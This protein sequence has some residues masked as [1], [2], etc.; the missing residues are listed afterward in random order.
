LFNFSINVKY[1]FQATFTIRG[2]DNDSTTSSQELDHRSTSNE[3]YDDTSPDS[4]EQ[5]IGE[6]YDEIAEESEHSIPQPISLETAKTIGLI[7]P[8]DATENDIIP[9]TSILE[10]S[11]Q[12]WGMRPEKFSFTEYRDKIQEVLDE[13][14]FQ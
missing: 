8:H 4:E 2:D 7:E 11:G 10:H 5:Y 12:Q 13:L 1:I 9:V 3:Y 6:E 14:Q